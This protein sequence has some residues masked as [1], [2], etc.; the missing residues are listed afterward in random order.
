[1]QRWSKRKPASLLRV[2]IVAPDARRD[3]IAR[4]VAHA[5]YAVVDESS[6]DVVLLDGAT[7]AQQ[8]EAALQAVAG[9]S[10]AHVYLPRISRVLAVSKSWPSAQPAC[11]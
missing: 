4:I 2:A 7:T 5:G 6:A 11:C 9:G 8:I 1:M 3:E 10:A